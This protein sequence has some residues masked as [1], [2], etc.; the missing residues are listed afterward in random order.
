[1]LVL[2]LQRRNHF[3]QEVIMP[4]MKNP[5]RTLIQS[6]ILSLMLLSY[7]EELFSRGYDEGVANGVL[8]SK[9]DVTAR[10]TRRLGSKKKKRKSKSKKKRS[11]Y[12]DPLVEDETEG[13]LV[14]D[15][16]GNAKY[17]PTSTSY[18]E[19]ED[20]IEEEVDKE[21]EFSLDEMMTIYHPQSRVND[22]ATQYENEF[23]EGDDEFSLDLP[24]TS[25]ESKEKT[26]TSQVTEQSPPKK[27]RPCY[28]WWW[29]MNC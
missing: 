20:F 9:N 12:G 19:D 4:F 2:F 22:V 26:T 7:N 24:M 1:M 13:S 27:S 23:L 11:Y 17:V 18:D 14:F 29:G 10:T 15:E 25:E 16:G 3:T 28:G 8:L 5:F 6:I 21:D